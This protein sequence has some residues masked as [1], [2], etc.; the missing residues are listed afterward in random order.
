MRL[1]GRAEVPDPRP[2]G[3]RDQ[4]VALSLV[5]RPI[6]DVGARRIADV[7]RLEQEDGSEVGGS[8]AVPGHEPAGSR[9]ADRSR[10]GS[11]SRPRAAPGPASSP[12]GTRPSSPPPAPDHVRVPTAGLYSR[13]RGAS[14]AGRL[15][16]RIR[17]PAT[18]MSPLGHPASLKDVQSVLTRPYLRRE[19]SAKRA[20]RRSEEWISARPCTEKRW[21][22][23]PRPRGIRDRRSLTPSLLVCPR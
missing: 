10:R 20:V 21:G 22:G 7:A 9:G 23:S 11:P 8:R 4:R 6:A 2:S 14:Y 3:A 16:R 19:T 18:S 5:E 15:Q 13:P 12:P 17:P 1:R